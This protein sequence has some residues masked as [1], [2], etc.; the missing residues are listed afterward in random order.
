M[1]NTGEAI[2]PGV[3]MCWLTCCI[4]SLC[5]HSKEHTASFREINL[6]CFFKITKILY[7]F[8]FLPHQCVTHLVLYEV[9]DCNVPFL[10]PKDS[11]MTGHGPKSS[12]ELGSQLFSLKAIFLPS[13]AGRHW[14]KTLFILLNSCYKDFFFPCPGFLTFFSFSSG[15]SP[16][17]RGYSQKTPEA[18]WLQNNEAN[19]PHTLQLEGDGR[20]TTEDTKTVLKSCPPSGCS[21]RLVG[22]LCSK[23]A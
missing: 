13:Q 23:L 10:D 2:K 11:S 14:R 15:L 1:H 16:R 20:W 12:S 6:K 3:E 9:H 19:V 22:T 7:S 18:T 21:T 4:L 5:L 17:I 8:A